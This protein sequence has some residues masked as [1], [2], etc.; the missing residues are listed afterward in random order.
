MEE[1]TLKMIRGEL[2]NAD[3]K[4]L[5]DLRVKCSKLTRRY[6]T[7]DEDDKERFEILNELLG[8]KGEGVFFRGPINFDYGFNTYVGDH[9][10]ANFNFT[11]LDVC[12][13]HIGNN[14]FMATNVSL[15]TALHPLLASERN[16]YFDEE[17]GYFHDDEYG[18]PIV[19]EDNVWIAANVLIG[20]GVTIGHDTVIG[21]GSVVL[22]DIPSGVLAAGNPCKVIRKLTENDKMKKNR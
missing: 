2:Y 13:V 15:I 21:A 7:L 16:G 12:P 11:V 9:S 4:E 8:S 18:A 19:I 17:V 1:N 5:H 14:V 10:Y 3:T 20:P 22:H 6:N